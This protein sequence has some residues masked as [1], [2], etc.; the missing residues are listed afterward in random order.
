MSKTLLENA[1]D[2]AQPETPDVI[3]ERSDGRLTLKLPSCIRRYIAL[4]IALFLVTLFSADLWVRSIA[5]QMRDW[6]TFGAI[7]FLTSIV[8]ACAIGFVVALHMATRC[9]FISV[10]D[11]T[12]RID[13]RSQVFCP[14]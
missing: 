8:V 10:V 13:A 6:G 5:A 3:V 7:A 11:K 9:G 14:R 2:I 4:L 1:G 12:F